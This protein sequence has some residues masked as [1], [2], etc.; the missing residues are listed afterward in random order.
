MIQ[1]YGCPNEPRGLRFGEARSNGRD[2]IIHRP[3]ITLFVLS[4][5]REMQKSTAFLETSTASFTLAMLYSKQFSAGTP[6]DWGRSAQSFTAILTRLFCIHTYAHINSQAAPSPH[7]KHSQMP[8]V[9]STNPSK[10]AASDI[11]PGAANASRTGCVSFQFPYNN[12]ITIY[13]NHYEG[14][15]M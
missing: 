1:P 9:L 14:K 4:S 7:T 12:I 8:V 11:A 10:R 15:G 6:K 3:I 5:P 2:Q 13:I